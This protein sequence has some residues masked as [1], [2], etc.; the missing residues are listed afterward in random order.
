MNNARQG[1]LLVKRLGLLATAGAN[2][3]VT[4]AA[5]GSEKKLESWAGNYIGW[6]EFCHYD[7]VMAEVSE[8]IDL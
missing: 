5:F 6:E 7:I 8:T 2:W 4:I 3:Q 1:K